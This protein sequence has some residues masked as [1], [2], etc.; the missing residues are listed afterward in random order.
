MNDGGQQSLLGGH[1]VRSA[2]GDG[3]SLGEFYRAE[4]G[5]ERGR[6]G[7]RSTEMVDL[8]CNGFRVEG[9]LGI[10]M[11]E[12]RGATR[13]AFQKRRGE[14]ATRWREDESVTW[15]RPLGGDG[16]LRGGR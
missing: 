15:L 6:E 16:V 14:G 1:A 4:G 5:Q 13:L 11:V 10:E 12:G 7:M 8:Q 3:G 2:V 9:E